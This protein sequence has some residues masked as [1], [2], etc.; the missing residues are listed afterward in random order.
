MH[1]LNMAYEEIRGDIIPFLKLYRSARS[2]GMNEVHVVNL[3]RIANDD[4][5]LPA[6][7]YRYE[8]L[9]QDINALENKKLN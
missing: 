3:L 2:A 7:E 9:K 1:G 6:V 8:G 4:N 5:N